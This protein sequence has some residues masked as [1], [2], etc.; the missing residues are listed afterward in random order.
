VLAGNRLSLYAVPFGTIR[1]IV[2]LIDFLGVF[3]YLN[4]PV[5]FLPA[6]LAVSWFAG[7]KLIFLVFFDMILSGYQIDG[8][9]GLSK[10]RRTGDL[11][12]GSAWVP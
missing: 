1:A 12:R 5:G 6:A 4:Q 8:L 9:V 10:N 11:L 3:G 2:Q 7:Y